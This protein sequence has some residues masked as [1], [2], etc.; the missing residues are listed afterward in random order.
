MIQRR[1]SAAGSTGM[2]IS[3]KGAIGLDGFRN[4]LNDRRFAG[5]PMVI[6]TPKG[7]DLAEDRENLATPPLTLRRRY[8]VIL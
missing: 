8:P 2:S 3:V 6:E 4:L 5:L 1:A 7:K